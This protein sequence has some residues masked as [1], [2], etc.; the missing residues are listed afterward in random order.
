[1]KQMMK[2]EDQSYNANEK[3]TEAIYLRNCKTHKVGITNEECV[4]AYNK[5]MTYDQVDYLFTKIF[6]DCLFAIIN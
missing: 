4:S 2:G 3:D 6:S 1:M 5:W